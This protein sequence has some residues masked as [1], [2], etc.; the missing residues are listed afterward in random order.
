[1][2]RSAATGQASEMEL[3][4]D[5]FVQQARLDDALFLSEGVRN[6]ELEAAMMFYTAQGDPEIKKAMSDFM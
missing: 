3:M 4:I 5:M 2:Q 6:D 1:M